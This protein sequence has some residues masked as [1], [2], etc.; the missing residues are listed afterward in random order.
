MRRPHAAALHAALLFG[1]VSAGAI[2]SA[3][4]PPPAAALAFR[5]PAGPMLLSRT[6]R[7]DLADGKAV[8]TTRRYRVSFTP[9]ASGWR[10]DGELVGCE[11][12]APPALAM[13]AEIERKRR[14]E[15]L[16]PLTLD[17]NGLIVP[18]SPPADSPGQGRD[19]VEQAI[20]ATLAQLKAN[21]PAAAVGAPIAGFLQQLQVL[22]AQ[23]ALTRWPVTLFLPGSESRDERRFTLPDG[24]EGT[25]TA[26]VS[27]AP[28]PGLAT[29]GRATRRVVTRIGEDSRTSREEWSLEPFA[30][31]SG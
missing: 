23:A 22:A 18:A 27:N 19:S 21:P 6:L 12:D 24:S 26:E 17:R 9:N 4:A 13:L 8:I 3:T 14:D 5:P 30:E 28:A 7:R 15:G 20:G 29:M 1:A 16:F 2:A 31:A 10:V 25:V 11:V